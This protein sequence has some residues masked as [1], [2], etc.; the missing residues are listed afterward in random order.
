[1]ESVVKLLMMFCVAM[2]SVSEFDIKNAIFKSFLDASY[3]KIS[4]LEYTRELTNKVVQRQGS[5]AEKLELA[6]NQI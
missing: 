3:D 2:K 1:M 4:G 6:Y 5:E